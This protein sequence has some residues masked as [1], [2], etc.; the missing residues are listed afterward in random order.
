VRPVRGFMVS[1]VGGK[2]RW[3][4][5]CLLG[6]LLGISGLN[7]LNSYVGRDFMTAIEDRNAPVFVAKMFL[8]IGVFALSSVAAGIY[9]FCEQRLGLLWRDWLTRTMMGQY[10]SH[11]MYYYVNESGRIRNPDQRISEDARA[12]A[13]TTLSFMLL[14]LNGIITAVAFSVVLWSIKPL[15][16]GV[17][18]GY[19]ITGTL[20]A[21][22]LGRPLVRFNYAQEDKEAFFRSDLIHVREN[23]ESVAFL[24]REG[25][26]RA[27]L[28][29]HLAAV[30]QNYKRIISVNRN[31]TF[32]TAGYNYM[33][34][35]IPI[36]IVAPL[37]IRGDIQFGVITQSAMA[38]SQLMGAFSLIVTQI[39]SLSSYAVVLLRI[40]EFGDAA[41]QIAARDVCLLEVRDQKDRITFEHLTL[42]SPRDG[43]TL[44]NDLTLSIPSGTNVLVRGDSDTVKVA[45]VRAIV[46]IWDR[47]EGH[48]IR[49]GPEHFFMMPER[50]YVAPGSL[51][52][53]VV[54][55]GYEQKVP[56]EQVL[57][58]LRELEVDKVVTRAGG[59]DVERDWDDILSLDEQHLLVFARL[60]I[61]APRFALLDRIGRALNEEQVDRV[62][63]VLAK[64]AVTYVHVAHGERSLGPYEAVLDLHEGGSWEWTPFEKGQ[65]LAKRMII[66]RAA[67]P[68][69]PS[70][71]VDTT[72]VATGLATEP[73]LIAGTTD[74]LQPSPAETKQ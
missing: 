43:R 9:T 17:A 47:G 20:L 38:F 5:I 26:M 64:N 60:I 62:L 3:F 54:R 66:G 30:V 40:G 74:L 44:V 52:E 22:L 18:V 2:A 45:F 73:G 57:A 46:G 29:E 42:R 59:L 10:L 63:A 23:A 6:L 72:A 33:I 8:Y 49:P 65:P 53:L 4:L 67:T 14:M 71:A 56:D 27:R 68:P 11:R 21:G 58:V 35:I 70:V 16:F 12:F 50:P 7:V 13:V 32:F 19:A 61:A 48:I 25:R 28:T 36:A 31:L 69:V 15:L 55:A 39:Q 51:R 34:Q 24:H 1:E 37:F 41:D